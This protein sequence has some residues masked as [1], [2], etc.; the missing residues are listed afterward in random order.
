MSTL[1]RSR[2]T[3]PGRPRL[4][5]LSP[6]THLRQVAGNLVDKRPE[7]FVVRRDQVRTNSYIPVYI[8][9]VGDVVAGNLWTVRNG[10]N[11]G[12]KFCFHTA[13]SIRGLT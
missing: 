2:V 13:L 9:V 8:V 12:F 1:N 6:V 3:D 7:S 5:A 11:F 10:L 4:V